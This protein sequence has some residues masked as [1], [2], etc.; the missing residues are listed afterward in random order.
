MSIQDAKNYVDLVIEMLVARG[1]ISDAKY[2]RMDAEL[3][4]R[5]AEKLVEMSEN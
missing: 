5:I 4:E 3:S 1:F 2:G